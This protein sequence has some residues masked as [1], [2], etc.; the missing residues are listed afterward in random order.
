MTAGTR[1]VV[2]PIQPDG[3]EDWTAAQLAALVT[4]ESM[5]GVAV[6]SRLD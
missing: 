3:T 5:I 2:L 6:V 4:R 1:F